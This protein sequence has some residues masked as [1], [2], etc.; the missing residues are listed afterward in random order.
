[1]ER[2]YR[3]LI[4]TLQW[5]ILW[6]GRKNWLFVGSDKG[7]ETATVMLSLIGAAKQKRLNTISYY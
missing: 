1:M 2:P 6:P 7:D 5:N 3:G 4:D